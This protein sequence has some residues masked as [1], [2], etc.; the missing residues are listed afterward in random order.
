MKMYSWQ[1]V[2]RLAEDVA[3]G[4]PQLP[5]KG[6]DRKGLKYERQKLNFKEQLKI[7]TE[8]YASKL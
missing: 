3:V 5:D 2:T 6:S 8:G 4:E 7:T 1:K